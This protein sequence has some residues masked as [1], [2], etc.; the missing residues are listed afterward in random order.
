LDYFVGLGGVQCRWGLL[1]AT[2]ETA[3]RTR[4]AK[5]RLFLVGMR[6]IRI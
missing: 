6:I 3:T 1:A 2:F 5:N 4:M